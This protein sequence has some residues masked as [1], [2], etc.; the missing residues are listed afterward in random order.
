VYQRKT[1]DIARAH[2][3]PVPLS[4]EA[5]AHRETAVMLRYDGKAIDGEN[6]MFVSLPVADLAKLPAP[7]LDL[8]E[9]DIDGET[10]FF[11]ETPGGVAL[12]LEAETQSSRLQILRDLAVSG[13]IGI[14]DCVGDLKIMG[15]PGN[16]QAPE[17]AAFEENDFAEVDPRIG[18]ALLSELASEHLKARTRDEDPSVSAGF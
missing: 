15:A 18:L 12:Y 4:D 11:R 5:M 7:G 16:L 1:G 14:L 6:I 10:A 2:R 17:R 8:T 13:A 9:R 3:F